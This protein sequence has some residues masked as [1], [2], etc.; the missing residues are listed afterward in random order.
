MSD[1]EKVYPDFKAFALAVGSSPEFQ[2]IHNILRND[3]IELLKI[4]EENLAIRPVFQTLYRTSLRSLFS[5]IEADIFGLNQ[6][7]PYENYNE[8]DRFPEKFK[9]T[10]KQIAKTWNK[11]EI[12]ELYFNS[13]FEKLQDLRTKRNDL[14]HPKQIIHLHKASIKE[15]NII[16]SVFEE[17]DAFMNDIMRNFF[18]S[19]KM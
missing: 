19:F 18:L 13:K 15:F 3:Y 12:Q 7:D 16:K 6:L 8:N 5:L 10:F 2:S 11:V 4:T 17:Y 1:H 14:M 9:H